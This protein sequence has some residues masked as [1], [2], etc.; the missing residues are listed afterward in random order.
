MLPGMFSRPDPADPL[1]LTDYT[2][3]NLRFFIE[4]EC[5]VCAISS[6]S[7]ANLTICENFSVG[8]AEIPAW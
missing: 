5:N 8:T 6:F 1:C 2:A 4:K 7:S 3:R